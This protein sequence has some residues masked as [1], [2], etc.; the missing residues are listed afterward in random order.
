M[1]PM[2]GT[3]PTIRVFVS[4]AQETAAHRDRCRALA[5]RLR[6]DGIDAWIDQYVPAPLEGWPRWMQ[7]QIAAAKFVILVCTPSFRRRF[8]GNETPGVGNGVTWEGLIANQMLHDNGALNEKLVPV[9]F[10]DSTLEAVP[11]VL[12]PFTR[13]T[14]W[15]DHDALYRH[16]TNQPAISPPPIGSRKEMPPVGRIAPISTN[17]ATSGAS[18]LN[19]LPMPP[20]AEAVLQA[21][22]EL[23]ALHELLMLVFDAHE[24]RTWLRFSAEGDVVLRGLPGES[25]SKAELM[26]K[27]TDLLNRRGLIDAEFFDRLR[28]HLPRQA[29]VID[30]VRARWLG[31]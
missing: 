16:L 10:E 14:L 21:R 6:D 20:G 17:T 23:Q 15:A 31:P 8:E 4:Y 11:I 7:Q 18:V 12:R 29:A 9:L 2:S 3:Q 25:A 27:A 5:D 19:T 13:Y 28:Q 22:N 30:H 24:L 26:F 1:A